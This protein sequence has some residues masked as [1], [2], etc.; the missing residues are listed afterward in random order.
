LRQQF[1]GLWILVVAEFQE[2][3]LS[4]PAHESKLFRPDSSPFAGHD[5][6]LTVIITELQMLF[7]LVLRVVQVALCLG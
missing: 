7:E 4:H 1:A 2:L 6:F 5:I 3:I